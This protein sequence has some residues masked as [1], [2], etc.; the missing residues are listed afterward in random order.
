MAVHKF[1]VSLHSHNKKTFKLKYYSMRKTLLT[2]FWG[3]SA[4]IF[5]QVTKAEVDPN[6]YIYLCFG[7]SNMEGN[8][9]AETMDKAVDKRFRLLATCDNSNSSPA[10]TKGNWYD[11]KP[12]LVNPVGG[13]GPTDYFG[14][15]M[16]AA[17]PANVKIGVVPV[18][19]GGSPIEMFDKDKYEQ[20]LAQN[21]N[22]WWAQIAK[23]N[24]GGNP[25]GRLIEMAK[26]AQEVGVI[27]GI[28]LHQGCSN[29]GDPNWPNMV[30]KIYN[31][32]LND[33]GLAADTVPLFVGET[34]RQENGGACYGHN[35]QVD[36]MPSVVPTSHVIS[37]EGLPGNGN[38]P[39]HFN[40]LGYRI[41]GRRYAACALELMGKDLICD[42]AYTLTYTYKNF[43][44]TKSLNVPASMSA[45]PGQRIPVSVTF[46]DNHQED[47]STS[48]FL[49]ISSNDFLIENGALASNFQGTGTVEISYTDFLRNEKKVTTM[50]DVKFFPI[51]NESLTVFKG[52]PTF[53]EADSTFTMKSGTHIGWCYEASADMSNY[54]YLV[55]KVQKPEK[56]GCN[57][58]V[59]DQN[60]PT[61]STYY[62][63]AIA[64]D[65]I[66]V[67]NL[68]EMVR[69][70]KTYDPSHICIVSL[71]STTALTIKL[72]DIYL[73]NED[74]TGIQTISSDRIQ[75]NETYDLQGRRMMEKQLR[76]GLYI[77]DGKKVF[78]K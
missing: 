9:A 40:A 38:D 51:K 65:S 16:V 47:V 60:K 66:V 39:W 19:M 63:K 32:M 58:R 62:N 67:I 52:E 28:L 8:A 48:K 25:Y 61:S 75:R 26:K 20:K 41:L 10:R 50:L 76:S 37:S 4:L 44:T 53:N 31:D 54:N 30:K 73:T 71:Y 68:H 17:L 35:V 24:Y 33:L 56:N 43:Y 6:F 13:L 36:R 7:Q 46:K 14:R 55:V 72:E 57:I 11:A 77:K 69:S 2:L 18:A 34:L 12:P 21:P 64:T 29:N 27:K 78:I 70:N 1:F 42:T 22:E 5:P 45:M 15:T 74:P 59:Y 3:L 23:N 49:T